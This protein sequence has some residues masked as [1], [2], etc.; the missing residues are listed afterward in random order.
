[1][2]EIDLVELTLCALAINS[3]LNIIIA[4]S[5]KD[6]RKGNHISQI[7]RLRGL[8][9][10]PLIL[11]PFFLFNRVI[12][13]LVKNEKDQIKQEKLKTQVRK[14]NLKNRNRRK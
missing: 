14:K 1:M 9:I 11:V 6:F 10:L 4:L 13:S 7:A 2:F 3:F 8:M 5:N 12:K